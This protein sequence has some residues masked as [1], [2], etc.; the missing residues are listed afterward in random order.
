MRRNVSERSFTKSFLRG[1]AVAVGCPKFDD[2]VAYE[3]KIKQII[4]C[5]DVK[6]IHVVYME[7]PCCAGLVHIAR[8]ALEKSGKGVP[9]EAVMIGIRGERRREQ[10]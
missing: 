9:F 6:S 5:A 7:V 10:G 1:K 3:N 8:E 2:V 4:E